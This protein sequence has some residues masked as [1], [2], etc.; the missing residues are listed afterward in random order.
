MISSRPAFREITS[1]LSCLTGDLFDH[2]HLYIVKDNKPYYQTVNNSFFP[3]ITIQSTNRI[4]LTWDS[5]PNQTVHY[6][7][8]FRSSNL[9]VMGLPSVTISVSGVV[10]SQQGKMWSHELAS[11]I[12]CLPALSVFDYVLPCTGKYP[13][14]ETAFVVLNY[15]IRTPAS[16]LKSN[17]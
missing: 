9:T 13:K 17:S 11:F 14:T 2:G 1:S 16:S 7:W 4:E 3:L 10:P 8:A 5:E 12:K 6:Q 15:T